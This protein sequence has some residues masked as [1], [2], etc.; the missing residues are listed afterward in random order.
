MPV[1]GVGRSQEM[2]L[3]IERAIREGSLDNIPV[4]VQGM[5]WDVTAIHT[6]YPDYFNS[7]VKNSIFH[8]DDNPF[9]S[10]VFKQV[11]S[12]KEM[13][14]VIEE[15][16]PCVVLATSGMMTGGASVEYFKHLA[17]NPKH[18]LVLTCYQGEG[19]LGRRIQNGEKNIVFME[20]D[21]QNMIKV[22]MDVHVI[23]GFSGHCSRDQLISFVKHLNPRPKRIIVNHGEQSKCLDLASSLHKMFRVE[24]TAP[25]HLAAVRIK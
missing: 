16:G 8:K 19:S 1:L 9:L 7:K 13:M 20:G 21:K 25:R 15:E 10:E 3:I 18:S 12:H 2:M 14:Q 22:N 17:E 4:Y 24:T 11:G 5:V 23:K 6:A